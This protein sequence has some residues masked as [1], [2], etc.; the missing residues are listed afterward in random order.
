[1]PTD[2]DDDP[3]SPMY[4]NG[5]ISDQEELDYIN[6]QHPPQSDDDDDDG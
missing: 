5:D 4:D 6:E 2:D 1:M 3:V